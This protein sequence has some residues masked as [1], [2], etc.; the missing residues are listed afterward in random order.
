MR[1]AWFALMLFAAEAFAAR[2]HAGDARFAWR[3]PDCVSS[4]TLLDH[5]LAQLVEAQD[6]KRLAGRVAV[7]RSV[8]RYDV[9]VTI[10]L[11]GRPLGTR[12]FEAD[13]CAR[14]AETAAVAASLAVYDGEGE[15]KGAAESG[16]SPDI[17]TRRPDPTPDFAQPRPAPKAPPPPL[18]EARVGVLGSLD[19]G[20]LPKPAWGG[21]LELQLGV[22]QRWSF[23]VLGH[24][25]SEQVRPVRAPQTVHLSALSGTSMACVAPLLAARYRLD[26]CAGAKLTQTRGRGNGFDVDRAASLTWLAPL[27]GLGFSVRAPSAVEWRLELDGTAPLA[28]HR[29]LVDGREVARAAVV[30]AAMRLGAVLRF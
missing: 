6:R 8:D 14:A 13:S 28:R 23:A 26:G 4:A 2:A 27:L 9:E 20:A 19:L 5:R 1:C 22:G 24:M 16:I 10:E 15:P 17:W 11:D 29:F 3:G 30:V 18:L 21:A 7:R 25:T 12:R